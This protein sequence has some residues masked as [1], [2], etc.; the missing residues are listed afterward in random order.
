MPKQE[1]LQNLRI[2]RS[3]FARPRVRTDS[4]ALDPQ[5]AEKM[6]LRAAIWLTPKS[7]EGF[8]RDDFSELGPQ[9]Q[10]ELQAAID[11]FLRVARQVPPTQ[12]PSPEQFQA[13]QA[14]L[15]KV[16]SILKPFLPI[17]Q[18]GEE[19]E[20]AL[21]NVDLPLWVANW[22]YE[23]EN[24]E[25]ETPSVWINLYVD[26]TVAPRKELG[27]F[28]SQITKKFLQALSAAGNPRWPYVRVRTAL[29]HKM[30]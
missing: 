25:Y 17:S 21:Q 12:P 11:E 29:E 13:A 30:V 4:P 20:E 7:V 14:S 5:E 15:A 18:E 10:P 9:Q 8:N 6:I 1:F 27:R 24:D 16:L 23:L 28:A 3:F 2:A 22:D 26:E 19:V